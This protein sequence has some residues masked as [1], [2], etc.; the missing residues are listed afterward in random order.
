MHQKPLVRGRKFWLKHT[1]Q[2][3]QAVVTT[4]ESRIN[5][6]TYDEEPDPPQL[7]LNDIGAVRLQT[8]KPLVYDGY[9]Q[10]RLTG[11]FILIEPG[12]NLTVAAGMLQ[13]PAEL[14]KPEYT[15]F[16]I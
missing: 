9:A 12:T 5:I 8:S 16:A 6:A 13:P 1:T 14:Y 3:V 4:L 10:N 2:T 11:A 7:L 15:D